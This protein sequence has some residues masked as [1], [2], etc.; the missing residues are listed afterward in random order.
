MTA[1]TYLG[2]KTSTMVYLLYKSILSSYEFY[3]KIYKS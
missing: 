3:L 1:V 2:I